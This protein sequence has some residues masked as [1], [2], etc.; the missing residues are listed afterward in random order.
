MGVGLGPKELSAV[1]LLTAWRND[2][3]TKK[4]S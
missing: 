4:R 3:I 2:G 1:L